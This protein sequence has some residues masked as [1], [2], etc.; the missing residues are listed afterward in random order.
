MWAFSFLNLDLECIR[1]FA[2]VGE[3]QVQEK[4][5]L[6]HTSLSLKPSSSL[7]SGRSLLR[8]WH[9]SPD[10]YDKLC[11]RAMIKEKNKHKPTKRN[12]PRFNHIWRCLNCVPSGSFSLIFAGRVARVG[13]LTWQVQILIASAIGHWWLTWRQ[14]SGIQ[15]SRRRLWTSGGESVALSMSQTS[16]FWKCGGCDTIFTVGHNSLVTICNHLMQKCL[17]ISALLWEKKKRVVGQL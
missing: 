16:P 15:V 6:L 17:A 3:L 12:S 4:E 10:P 9:V 14:A 1:W 8:F 11:P 5:V 7:S 13:G 2:L